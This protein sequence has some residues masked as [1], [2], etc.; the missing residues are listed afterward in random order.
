MKGNENPSLVPSIIICTVISLIG[1]CLYLYLSTAR[2]AAGLQFAVI[3]YGA[4]IT[5]HAA[6]AGGLYGLRGSFISVPEGRK[7]EKIGTANAVTLFRLYSV[8]SLTALFLLKSPRKTLFPLLILSALVYGSDFLDG[9]I[10]RKADARSKIGKYLDSTT[11]Y[12]LLITLSLTFLIIGL[13]PLWYC[14]LLLVRLLMQGGF[15]IITYVRKKTFEH[16]STFLGKAAV[17]SVMTVFLFVLFGWFKIPYL[18][19]PLVSSVLIWLSAGI[20]LVSVGDKIAVF[21][22]K[23]Q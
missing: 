13:L 19:N 16:P 8:P 6:I 2:L 7:I 20:L 4:I 5:W 22:K 12:I 11:D 21:K 23:L 18:G 15:I 17:F 3:S 9:F 14:I 10:A 1:Q